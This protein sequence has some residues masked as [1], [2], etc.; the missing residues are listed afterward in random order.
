MLALIAKLSCRRSANQTINSRLRYT[1]LFHYAIAFAEVSL[2]SQRSTNHSF[3]AVWAHLLAPVH[4]DLAMSCRVMSASHVIHVICYTHGR[5]VDGNSCVFFSLKLF[6]AIRPVV[7]DG[8][9]TNACLAWCSK[10]QQHRHM[11]GQAMAHCHEIFVAQIFL[12]SVNFG[13]K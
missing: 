1:F 3:R 5:V 2:C 10:K 11:L 9:I 7:H 12:W 4:G 8:V 6:V 13:R